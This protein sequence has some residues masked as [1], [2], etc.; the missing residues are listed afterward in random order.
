M[1]FNN[2]DGLIHSINKLTET[3]QDNI[4]RIE[5]R[6]GNLENKVEQLLIKNEALTRLITEKEYEEQKDNGITPSDS[7]LSSGNQVSEL[8]DDNI[9]NFHLN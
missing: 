5:K 6:I 1:E 9:Q 7:S 8:N 3:I 2:L 4:P